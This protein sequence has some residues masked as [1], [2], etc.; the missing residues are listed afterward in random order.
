V[1]DDLFAQTRGSNDYEISTTEMLAATNDIGAALGVAELARTLA[2]GWMDLRD[3]VPF[4]HASAQAS[5]YGFVPF[6]DSRFGDHDRVRRYSE[7]SFARFLALYAE[8]NSST[9][10]TAGFL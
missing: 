5:L 6:G 10:P 9:T 8:V 1:K 3:G 4:L 7:T 2:L